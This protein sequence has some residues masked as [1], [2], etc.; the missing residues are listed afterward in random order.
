MLLVNPYNKSLIEPYR[1]LCCI[2][3]GLDIGI[4]PGGGG[5]SGARSAGIFIY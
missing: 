1:V 4:L 3:A 5:G 2:E